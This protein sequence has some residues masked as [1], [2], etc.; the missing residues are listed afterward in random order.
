MYIYVYI[1]VYNYIYMYIIM[2]MYIIIYIY[3][4]I[5]IYIIIIYYTYTPYFQTNPHPTWFF[6]QRCA[7]G[8]TS[9]LRILQMI[10]WQHETLAN[11]VV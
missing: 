11:S 5:Y 8:S 3:M 1:Y 9:S 7:C 2:Y 4:Y 6:Q 10:R